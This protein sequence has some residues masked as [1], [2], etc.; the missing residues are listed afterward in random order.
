MRYDCKLSN[1]ES[2][3]PLNREVIGRFIDATVND[4]AEAKR[5]LNAHPDLRNATWIG[6]E[7]ILNFLAIENFPEGV[8]FCI[9]NGFDPNQSDDEFGTTPLFYACMLNYPDVALVLLQHGANP[10]AK[11]E[12]YDNPIHCCVQKGNADLL[13]ILIIHGADPRYTTDLGETVFDNWPNKVAKQSALAR[14][15]HKHNVTSNGEIT[16]G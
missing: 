3:L 7:N 4:R 15:L 14:V 10:N 16:N 2:T 11:S 13:D 1:L 6:D 8:R 5:L 12:I 9:E